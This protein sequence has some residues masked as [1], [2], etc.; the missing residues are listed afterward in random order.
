MKVNKNGLL[1]A[2]AVIGLVGGAGLSVNAHNKEEEAL[3]W[4]EDASHFEEEVHE[5][6]E[7]SKTD[8][9]KIPSIYKQITDVSNTLIDTQKQ[10]VDVLWE[11]GYYH[12]D[13]IKDPKYLEA[14]NEFNKLIQSAP[15]QMKESTWYNEPTWKMTLLRNTVVSADATALSYIWENEKGEFVQMVTANYSARTGKLSD[16]VMYRT[17][18]GAFEFDVNAMKTSEMDIT[19]EVDKDLEEKIKEN[20]EKEKQ[21]T[22]D[23]EK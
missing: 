14:L 17:K 13:K 12:R 1:T 18:Q 10:M 23:N 21:Q 20:D 2:V 8:V 19:G 3:K 15:S 22:K 5:L 16:I 9:K 4:H 6:K 7:K 11:D